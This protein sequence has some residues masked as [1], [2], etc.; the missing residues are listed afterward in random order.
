MAATEGRRV[1]VLFEWGKSKEVVKIRPEDL[2]AY[3]KAKL[4]SSSAS[5]PNLL[6]YDA[7]PPVE[8]NYILQKWSERWKCYVMLTRRLKM[9]TG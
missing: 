3:V 6:P 5:S 2:E 7:C 1:E 9:G 8:G 4:P